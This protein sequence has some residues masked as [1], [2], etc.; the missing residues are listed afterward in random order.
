[1]PVFNEQDV[2]AE[3]VAE[4]AAVLE[5]FEHPEFVLINDC[6]T[7]D[8]FSILESLKAKYPYLRL[9]NASQ[10]RGHGPSLA[11]AYRESTGDYVFHADSDRQFVAED[12]WLLWQK[13]KAEDLDLVIGYREERKD[14]FARLVLTRFVRAF[15][16][17]LFHLQLQ[18]SN[19]P[20]RLYKRE[21]LNRILTLLPEEPMIP[22][23]LMVIAANKM[24]MRVGWVPVR[25]LA[26]L[27][28]KSFLRSWKVFRLCVPAV[29]EV[30]D[31][32]R[33]LARL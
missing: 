6:S 20:F 16:L 11:R 10:N 18:D 31:F 22:S 9:G 7:D 8:T 5:K 32:R 23:I 19:S 3:V 17:M 28:G 4:F 2:I 33:R 24:R 14:S 15:L 12:F 21:A 30:L 13:Q 25:H 29:K 27:T 1:M 26:R